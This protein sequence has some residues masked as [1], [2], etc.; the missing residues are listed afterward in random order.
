[1]KLFGVS[2]Q[3]PNIETL[4]IPR[5]NYDIVFKAQ[6][7]LDP[8]PF[9]A[10]CPTPTP[11]RVMKPNEGFKPDYKDPNYLALVEKW[12]EKKTSWMIIESLKVTEGLTWDKVDYS[13]PETW[14]LWMDELKESYFTDSEMTRIVNLVYSANG[15]NDDKIDE[16]R[17]RFL[18]GTA[19]PMPVPHQCPTVEAQTTLSGE[20]VKDSESSHQA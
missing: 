15:L 9:Y 19:R 11:P 20:L 8:D 2:I 12:A 18:S 7:I 3:G 1:M 13:N 14:T 4:V 6:A 16:A 5:A 10:L 17:N